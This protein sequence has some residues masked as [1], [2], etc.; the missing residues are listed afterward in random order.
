MFNEDRGAYLFE[1]EE[2]LYWRNDDIDID[3]VR[4]NLFP[5]MIQE[6]EHSKR[7]NDIVTYCND[8][9]VNE[10]MSSCPIC[11]ENKQTI[12]MVITNCFHQFCFDCIKEHVE[13]LQKTL[14]TPCCALCRQLYLSF[15][16]KDME[17]CILLDTLCMSNK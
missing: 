1:E 17:K 16:L 7:I 5:H 10:T 12:D 8:V 11:F 4:E 3:L 15:E 2:E 9:Y 13:T 6:K 14:H